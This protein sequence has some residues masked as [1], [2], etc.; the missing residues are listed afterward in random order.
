MNTPL[1]VDMP[2][3]ELT[4]A[5]LGVVV[6]RLLKMRLVANDEADYIGSLFDIDDVDG[7][8]FLSGACGPSGRSALPAFVSSLRGETVAALAAVRDFLIPIFAD[9]TLVYFKIGDNAGRVAVVT[10]T[11]TNK[12]CVVRICGPLPALAETAY[13]NELYLAPLAV[14]D[15]VAQFDDEVRRV[16]SIVDGPYGLRVEFTETIEVASLRPDVVQLGLRRIIALQ[17]RGRA[18]R[19]GDSGRIFTKLYD[20]WKRAFSAPKPP[21]ILHPGSMPLRFCL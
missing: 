12:L 20:P 11:M 7:A 15:T 2:A 6:A 18:K 4:P 16:G 8:S 13:V 3:S 1:R 17:R 21:H 9:G 19:S 10:A 5:E 14:G